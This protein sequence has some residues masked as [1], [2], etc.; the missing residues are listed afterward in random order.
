M[1]DYLPSCPACARHVHP[2]TRSCP[3]CDAPVPER[4]ARRP[5]GRRLS[6]SGVLAFGAAVTASLA[7]GCGSGT[8]PDPEDGGRDSGAMVEDAGF[9]AGQLATPYGAPPMRDGWV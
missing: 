8:G 6:R 3:F 7:M 1:D 5:P 4:S 2:G 9:D